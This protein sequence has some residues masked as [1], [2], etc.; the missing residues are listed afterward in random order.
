[1]TARI[2]R[3]PS[4]NPR[5]EVVQYRCTPDELAALQAAADRAGQP[6]RAYARD[7]ALAKA[8]RQR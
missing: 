7:A 1:M 6:M 4:D 3:P 8:K 5:T 2:G